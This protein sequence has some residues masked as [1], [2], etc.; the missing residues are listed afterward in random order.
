[1]QTVGETSGMLTLELEHQFEFR[2][3]DPWGN[4]KYFRFHLAAAY[5][6]GKQSFVKEIV[7]R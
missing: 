1:M 4:S 2:L 6:I 3:L 7:R 5:K